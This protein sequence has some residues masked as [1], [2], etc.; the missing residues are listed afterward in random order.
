MYGLSTLHK[1]LILKQN[2]SITQVNLLKYSL[3][4]IKFLIIRAVHQYKYIF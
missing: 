4:C 1:S 2:I 3:Y